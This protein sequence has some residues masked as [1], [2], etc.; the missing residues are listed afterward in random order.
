MTLLPYPSTRRRWEKVVR[1]FFA[2]SERWW[3]V[4]AEG[5]GAWL[6]EWQRLCELEVFDRDQ[7]WEF[8][9]LSGPH[10]TPLARGHGQWHATA[11]RAVDE[12]RAR[13]TVY[14]LGRDRRQ[15]VVGRGGV[16][17]IVAIEPDLVAL[18]SAW[19]VVAEW[20]PW[21]SRTESSDEAAVIEAARVE[22]VSDRTAVRRAHRWSSL[23]LEPSATEGEER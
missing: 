20:E 13:K 18:V 2:G 8:L 11:E 3:E 15:C 23:S 7:V 17:V 4:T 14:D 12:G 21:R 19:R 5:L 16:T 1:H 6:P 9:P 22:R 10:S